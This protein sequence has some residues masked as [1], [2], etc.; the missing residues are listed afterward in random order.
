MITSHLRSAIQFI[1]LSTEHFKGHSF[2]IG[3]ATHAASLGFSDQVIQKLGRW[4]SDAFKH[5]I[6]ILSFK[7]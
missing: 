3:E 6:R 2:R 1:G 5:Y 7:L 4:N